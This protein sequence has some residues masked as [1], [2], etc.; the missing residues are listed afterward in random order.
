MS[1][2]NFW[3]TI[4]EVVYGSTDFTSS[5]Q[6]IRVVQVKAIRDWLLHPQVL[7][8]DGLPASE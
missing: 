1:R 5:F 2:G 3:G 6:R 4:G 8:V 7:E